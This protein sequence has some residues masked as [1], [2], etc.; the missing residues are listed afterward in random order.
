[1]LQNTGGCHTRMF[2]AKKREPGQARLV[3]AAARPERRLVAWPEMFACLDLGSDAA[4]GRAIPGPT[5][6]S[7]ATWRGVADRA[8]GGSF[9]ERDSRRAVYNTT[10]CSTPRDK[11]WPA[12]QDPPVRRHLPG[13]V[14]YA[15]APGCRR[16][17]RGPLTGLRPHRQA[18]VT[19]CDSRNYSGDCRRPRAM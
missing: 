13:E 7:S 17:G 1:M 2:G 5:C 6:S 11:G 12:T 18:I 19:T 14:S 3:E 8:V 10:C 4:S 15:K 16:T 9:C